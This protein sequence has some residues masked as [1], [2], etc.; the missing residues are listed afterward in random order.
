MRLITFA[1]LPLHVCMSDASFS[2]AEGVISSIG[3]DGTGYKQYKTGPGVLLSFTHTENIL[4][5][6]TLDKGKDG[7]DALFSLSFI[8][9]LSV[10]PPF[11]ITNRRNSGPKHLSPQI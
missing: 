10:S 8:L 5:W 9:C 1:G 11:K 3:V 2:P 6:V 7:R 4:L